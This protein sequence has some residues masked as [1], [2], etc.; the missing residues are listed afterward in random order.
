MCVGGGDKV[1]VEEGDKLRERCFPSSL[2]VLKNFGS[3]GG[4]PEPY[5]LAD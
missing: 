2:A 4:S 3:C 1:G 5:C